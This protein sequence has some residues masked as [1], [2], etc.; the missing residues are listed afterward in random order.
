METKRYPI[1]SVCKEDILL[2][3]EG[4]D[5]CEKVVEVIEQ[6]NDIEMKHLA[7]KL[8]DDYCEQLYWISLKSIFE[9]K[10]MRNVK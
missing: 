8:A 1:T 7:Q 5:D 10:F 4:S 6:I 9:D 3:Y 2:C